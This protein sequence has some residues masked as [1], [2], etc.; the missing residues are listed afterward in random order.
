MPNLSFGQFAAVFAK[1]LDEQNGGRIDNLSPASRVC[2]EG[3]I[4]GDD[5]PELLG[6]IAAVYGTDFSGIPPFGGP[7]A[8]L[9]P[10]GVVITLW[11]MWRGEEEQ[12]V[13]V[14]ELHEA[15]KAGSWK[16]AFPNKNE[17][18]A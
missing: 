7:E 6:R 1:A 9:S 2:H 17:G 18:I 5:L 12:D 13:T 8:G 4:A 15:V 16:A 10:V 11:K 14:G 3:G